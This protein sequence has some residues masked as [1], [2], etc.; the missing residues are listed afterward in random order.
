VAACVVVMLLVQYLK[1]GGYFRRVSGVND[2][3]HSIVKLLVQVVQKHFVP[4]VGAN[5]VVRI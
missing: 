1:V 3:K 5:K 4:N 2:Q